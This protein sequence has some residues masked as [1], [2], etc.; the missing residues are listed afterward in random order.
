MFGS[1]HE[2]CSVIVGCPVAQ[3]SAGLP[4]FSGRDDVGFFAERQNPQERVGAFTAQFAEVSHGGPEQILEFC[5]PFIDRCKRLEE[6]KIHLA[7][8]ECL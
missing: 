6:G 2:I 1:D 7:L 8:L 4:I 3:A 5:E